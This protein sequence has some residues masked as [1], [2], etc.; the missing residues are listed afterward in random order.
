[1]APTFDPLVP[2]ALIVDDSEDDRYILRRLL[3]KAA[4]TAEIVEK[5]HGQ[6]ALDYLESYRGKRSEPL[7][8]F[9]DI[10]MPVMGGFEFLEKFEQNRRA[11]NFEG[12]ILIMFTSSEHASDQERVLNYDFVKGYVVKMPQSWEA[13]REQIQALVACS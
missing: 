12:A 6:E 4:V 9:L 3:K 13:L 5:V 7:L 10:N 8:I 11:W 2:S 1:M